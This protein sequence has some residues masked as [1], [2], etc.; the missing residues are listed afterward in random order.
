MSTVRNFKG[1][2]IIMKRYA[3]LPLMVAALAGCAEIGPDA[4]GNLTPE[5]DSPFVIHVGL[6]AGVPE[7]KTSFNEETYAVSWSTGDELAVKIDGELYKFVKVDGVDNAFSCSEF[8]PV[9]GVE[10]LYD[11]L[12][13][14]SLNG[15]F[16]MSGG[17]K[18]PMHGKGKAVGS[19]SPDVQ[20]EQLTALIK[21]TV[22]NE[23]VAGTATLTSLSVERADGGILGGKHT[24]DGPVE[25]ETVSTTTV[26]SQNKKIAAGESIVMFLQC[27]PFTA[28]PGSKLLV[29]CTVDGVDYVTEKTFTKEVKF[30]AGKVNRTYVSFLSNAIFID[31]GSKPTE[32]WNNITDPKSADIELLNPKS[33]PTG[34]SLSLAG[35]WKLQD[36]IT[37]EPTLDVVYGNSV[38]PL[39]AWYDSFLLQNSSGTLKFSGMPADAVY[40][41]T[42]VAYRWNGTPSARITRFGLTGHEDFGAKDI[43][44]GTRDSE[45]SDTAN[46]FAVFEN[47]KPDSEGCVTLTVTPITVG[48][49]CDAHLSAI[50]I[51]RIK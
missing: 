35:N 45:L 47:V 44:Q 1:G 43:N 51:E 13:P 40:R 8:K 15:Q 25:G 23:N 2:D 7:S 50:K 24:I 26:G 31:F 34:L 4:V 37:Y 39:S 29:K 10:Y 38:Y 14:Y 42:I 36:P 5:G 16:T 12:Y 28:A 41:F 6:P 11:I 33:E 30:E 48:K 22:K 32:G 49:V 3:I 21:V 27:A 19:A 46:H 18:A 17:V 9:E 20:L